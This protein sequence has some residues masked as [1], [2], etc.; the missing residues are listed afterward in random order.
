MVYRT[1]LL[2]YLWCNISC[3][4]DKDCKIIDTLP[5]FLIMLILQVASINKIG[6]LRVDAH[7]A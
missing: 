5:T 4:L 1:I 6:I 3:N 2:R 7:D